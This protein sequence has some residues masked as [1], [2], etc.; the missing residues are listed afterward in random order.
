[1]GATCVW[2]L[3]DDNDPIAVATHYAGCSWNGLDAGRAFLA[4]FL[5]CFIVLFVAHAVAFIPSQFNVFGPVISPMALAAI[6]GANIVAASL[7]APGVGMNPARCLGSAIVNGGEDHHWIHWIA[8]L[9]ASIVHGITH[10]LS[11]PYHRETADDRDLNKK[12]AIA[13]K[14]RE[15]QAI[16]QV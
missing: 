10:F 7:V 16:D 2:G 3:L 15:L 13:G 1:M 14:R 8:P 12:A 4:E 6:L 11:P 5:F 9:T